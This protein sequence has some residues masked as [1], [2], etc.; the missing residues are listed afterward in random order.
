MEKPKIRREFYQHLSNIYLKNA[1]NHRFNQSYHDTRTWYHRMTAST[2]CLQAPSL[3][4]GS[5]GACLQATKNKASCAITSD[6]Q[7]SPP[8]LII[9]TLSQTFVTFVLFVFFSSLLLSNYWEWA[10][11]KVYN[12]HYQTEAWWHLFSVKYVIT[13]KGYSLW[14]SW[15]NSID[16]KAN[17][18]LFEHTQPWQ[19]LV[20]MAPIDRL[21]NNFLVGLV[22]KEE[23]DL[24][25]TQIYTAP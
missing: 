6:A 12:L 20:V 18:R 10:H 9:E 7:N 8:S 1:N 24:S 19:V 15:E 5:L 23:V 4:S 2:E 13:H 16:H 11:D 21:D 3:C 22:F 14:S 25:A 17:K